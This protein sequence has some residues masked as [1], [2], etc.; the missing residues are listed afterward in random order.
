MK[1]ITQQLNKS[2]WASLVM[3]GIMLY[4]AQSASTPTGW[5]NSWDPNSPYGFCDPGGSALG[6]K[7]GPLLAVGE[8]LTDVLAITVLDCRPFSGGAT[9]KVPCP[10]GSPY[11]YCTR[12]GNDGLGNDISLGVLKRNA[13]TD[14]NGLYTGCPAGANLQS[15]VRLVTLAN[16][17]P[18]LIKGIV[19]LTCDPATK[20][21]LTKPTLVTCPAGP[22]PYG[23]YCLR[24]PNDGFGNSVTIGVVTANGAGD[25]YALYGECNT[26]FS[27][28]G[29]K[30]GFQAKSTLVTSV[31]RS[32]TNVRSIDLL[33]CNWPVGYGG[34]FPTTMKVGACT[35]NPFVP[36]SL[37]N[38]YAYCIWGTD[39]KGNGVIAGINN[40]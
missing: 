17:D 29:M 31:G 27:S 24:T 33:G 40:N 2:F 25:A 16:R 23:K 22:D 28:V 9:A 32:M 12:T 19:T 3:C 34:S 1:K 21:S 18:R 7:T 36:T 10:T 13:T 15:K 37:A 14:P 8:T 5:N 20:P 30:S 39:A 4:S 6:M 38:R 35:G 11:A 26:I